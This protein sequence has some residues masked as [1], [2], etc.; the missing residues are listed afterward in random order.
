MLNSRSSVAEIEAELYSAGI[1]L[2]DRY[3]AEYS[4]GDIQSLGDALD[5]AD[6][7]DAEHGG[8][9][10]KAYAIRVWLSKP[11]WTESV[12][13]IRRAVARQRRI[14]CCIHETGSFAKN[15]K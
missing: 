12:S 14:C 9:C 2:L 6:T 3:F 4:M 5:L 10:T 1:P 15:R 8:D 11:Y 7:L 13:S